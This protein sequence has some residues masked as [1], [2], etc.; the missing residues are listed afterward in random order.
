MRFLLTA[1]IVLVSQPARADDKVECR[2]GI[3]MIKA[4]IAKRPPQAT[5]TKLQTALRV[6]ERED[7]EEEFDECADAIK[8]RSEGARPL[9]VPAPIGPLTL[10]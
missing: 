6:A 7:K 5:L 10:R 2:A 9:D 8:D 4:E 1:L 3:Q